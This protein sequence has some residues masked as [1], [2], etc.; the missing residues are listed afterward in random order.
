MKSYYRTLQIS[1]GIFLKKELNKGTTVG[2]W[3]IEESVTELQGSIILTN[4]DSKIFFSFSSDQRKKEWL[5]TRL[6]LKSICG[7]DIRI[8]RDNFNKPS[9]DGSN[10]KISISH[11]IK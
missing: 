8:T 4:E 9:L 10:N 2:M 1:M 5:S 6:L 3:I 7:P 11:S